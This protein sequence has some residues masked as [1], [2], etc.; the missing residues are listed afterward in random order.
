MLYLFQILYLIILVV[1]LV[2]SMVIVFHI[3]K[4]SY[5]AKSKII[6]LAIFLSVAAVLMITNAI[7]FCMLPLEK[8]FS[9][10]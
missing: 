3:L 2:L 4:Y 6:T 5:T 10:F 8:F 1:M 9:G 7:S